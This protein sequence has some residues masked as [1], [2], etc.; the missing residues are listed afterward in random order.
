MPRKRHCPFIEFEA[1]D[2]D[3]SSNEE[4]KENVITDVMT[5]ED[6]NFINEDSSDECTDV[7]YRLDCF[8]EK[9]RETDAQIE[10]A[11]KK[12]TKTRK[13]KRRHK[14]RKR[15][16]DMV[17]VTPETFSQ[18][19]EEAGPTVMKKKFTNTTDFWENDTFYYVAPHQDSVEVQSWSQSSFIEKEQ[20]P[21]PKMSHNTQSKA[22][23]SIFSKSKA[24]E[25][26]PMQPPQNQTPKG[27]SAPILKKDGNVYTTNGENMGPMNQL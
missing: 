10:E 11:M 26:K 16:L 18:T 23:Y 15:P 9:E 4:E 13:R 2:S 24:V 3:A 17:K 8:E 21:K 7:G 1:E 22:L 25:D 5:A 19:V 27:Y 14:D 20:K 12:Y 6:Q